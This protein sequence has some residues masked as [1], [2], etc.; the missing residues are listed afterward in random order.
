MPKVIGDEETLMNRRKT[1][2]QKLAE[3]RMSKMFFFWLS[4]EEA[5]VMLVYIVK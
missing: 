1:K 5:E 3:Y 2:K 4:K